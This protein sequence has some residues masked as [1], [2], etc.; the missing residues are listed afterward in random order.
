MP[1][2]RNH[3]P[4]LLGL[5][6]TDQVEVDAPEVEI[7]PTALGVPSPAQP[8]DRVAPGS[9]ADADQDEEAEMETGLGLGVCGRNSAA[10]SDLVSQRTRGGGK[11]VS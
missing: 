7:D 1:R 9:G 3:G 2:D 10:A 4:T 11:S 6:S 5:S 8:E